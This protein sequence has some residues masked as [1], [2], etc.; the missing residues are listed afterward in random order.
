MSRYTGILL[1]FDFQ[2]THTK[3]AELCKVKVTLPTKMNISIEILEMETL[4]AIVKYEL[5][6]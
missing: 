2:W 6:T 3:N 1:C 5:L 4:H